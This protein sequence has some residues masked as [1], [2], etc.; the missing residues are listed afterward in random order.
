MLFVVFLLPIGSASANE[1]TKDSIVYNFVSS[2]A[3]LYRKYKK[4]L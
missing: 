4:D 1:P 2:G 3:F